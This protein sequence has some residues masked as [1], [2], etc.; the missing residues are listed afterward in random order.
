M[1]S[2]KILENHKYFES[3]EEDEKIVF[4]IRRH[5]TILVAPFIVG[6]V[7]LGLTGLMTLIIGSFES[8]TLSETG[9]TIFTCVISLIVL[10][11]ILYVFISWLIRYL[12]IIILTGEHLVEIQQ[13]AIFSRKVSELDLDCIEDASSIQKGFIQT[14]FHF[15]NVLIQTAGELPNFNLNGIADPNGVQQKIMETKESY[16]KN[17]LYNQGNHDLPAQAQT[18]MTH[19]TNN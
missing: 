10:Y 6:T 17:N 12:N 11:T 1:R 4:I 13:L 16:M 7:I 3:Q 19:G 5:W 9:E 14:M 18:P 15:G 2:M 8:V